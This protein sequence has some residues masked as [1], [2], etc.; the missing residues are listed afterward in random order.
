MYI[1]SFV[2]ARCD[3]I[4][5]VQAVCACMFMFAFINVCLSV[6]YVCAGTCIH[7]QILM[8]ACLHVCIHAAWSVFMCILCIY[9]CNARSYAWMCVVKVARGMCA[10]MYLCYVCLY[11]AVVARCGVTM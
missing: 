3:V 4:T 1:M 2:V 6:T 11:V 7:K 5:Y 8:H 10:Y 9:A